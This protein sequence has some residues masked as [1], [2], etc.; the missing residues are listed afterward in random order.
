MGKGEPRS[1]LEEE[2]TGAVEAGD[3]NEQGSRA[4]DFIVRRGLASHGW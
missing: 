4:F 3:V 1:L 2:L